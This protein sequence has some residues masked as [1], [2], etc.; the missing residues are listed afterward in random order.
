MKKFTGVMAF[1]SVLII[2]LFFIIGI[3]G[4]STDSNSDSANP[5]TSELM[6]IWAGTETTD[7]SYDITG[8]FNV[9]E[10]ESEHLHLPFTVIVHGNKTKTGE[11]L[12]CKI[13]ISS[14]TLQEDMLKINMKRTIGGKEYTAM[15]D[16]FYE[17]GVISGDL[18]GTWVNWLA[19]NYL[20]IDDTIHME[21]NRA[22]LGKAGNKENE[23]SAGLYT[24]TSLSLNGISQ[25]P[26]GYITVYLSGSAAVVE[27]CGLT[28]AGYFTKTAA[29]QSDAA[30][31][32]CTVSL[33]YPDG[34]VKQYDGTLAIAGDGLAFSGTNGSDNLVIDY[35]HIHYSD[36]QGVF[37][38]SE[39]PL[40]YDMFMQGYNSK[41]YL[42][43][44][45]SGEPVSFPRAILRFSPTG[46]DEMF[47]TE[48]FTNGAWTEN[49]KFYALP[50]SQGNIQVVPY[51]YPD[52]LTFDQD[53]T[54]FPEVNGN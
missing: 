15:F 49:Q 54:F 41:G 26:V 44:D 28:G 50:V 22:Q 33:K 8:Y 16:G 48:M 18:S 30:S 13:F 31:I 6:G 20:N 51:D 36:S 1:A 11:I 46:R 47:Q 4:C 23:I 38:A 3:P 5:S 7:D 29:T 27:G 53:L 45:T 12:T 19:A 10:D 37:R 14:I 34:T 35:S 39:D 9:R 32:S 21:F 17:N 43:M 25:E 24:M 42:D 40:V 2:A 52:E